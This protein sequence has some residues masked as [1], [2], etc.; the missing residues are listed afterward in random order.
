MKKKRT[1]STDLLCLECGNIF[2]IARGVNNLKS[3]GHIKHL[4]CP[5]CEKL[6]EHFEVRDAG[7]MRK[8]LEFQPNRNEKEQ[9][10]YELLVKGY[11]DENA[12]KGISKQILR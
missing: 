6:T 12:R 4:M 3:N 8:E 10:I 7:L 1:M 5:R 2:T 9:L 11:E